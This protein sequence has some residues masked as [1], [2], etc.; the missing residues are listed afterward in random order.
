MKEMN[1]IEVDKIVLRAQLDQIKEVLAMETDTEES[2]LDGLANV[3]RLL[4]ESEYEEVKQREFLGPI[5][6]CI[7]FKEAT[8][9]A[10][11]TYFRDQL[12][13][14]LPVLVVRSAAFAQQLMTDFN[15]RRF[16][17]TISLLSCDNYRQRATTEDSSSPR[18]SGGVSLLEVL[19]VDES[20]PLK[21]LFASIVYY[22]DDDEATVVTTDDEEDVVAMK[23]PLTGGLTMHVSVHAK[24]PAIQIEKLLQRYYEIAEELTGL[25]QST[26]T[27]DVATVENIEGMVRR[28]MELI[29]GIMG[30]W[31][32]LVR[33]GFVA[34]VVDHRQRAIQTQMRSIR[35]IKG[36]L[37]GIEWRQRLNGRLIE[38]VSQGELQMGEPHF[39]QTQIDELLSNRTGA[40]HTEMGSNWSSMGN[41]EWSSTSLAI[42]Y[43][44]EHQRFLIEHRQVIPSL[45]WPVEIVLRKFSYVDMEIPVQDNLSSL[46]TERAGQL[47][48]LTHSYRALLRLKRT[49]KMFESVIAG[50]HVDAASRTLNTRE[51]R[52]KTLL[53]IDGELRQLANE[54]NV[55][56]KSRVYRPKVMRF[57]KRLREKKQKLTANPDAIRLGLRHFLTAPQSVR[58]QTLMHK[59]WHY[60]AEFYAEVRPGSVDQVQMVCQLKGTAAV[61][62]RGRAV[63]KH[64]SMGDM[65]GVEVIFRSAE[66]GNLSARELTPAAI[67]VFGIAVLFAKMKLNDVRVIVIGDDIDLGLDKDTL[68]DIVQLFLDNDMQVIMQN[69]DVEDNDDGHSGARRLL[70]FTPISTTF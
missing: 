68:Q 45:F 3:L 15:D 13:N 11:Q 42:D 19:Q 46:S 21:N 12:Q 26:T 37:N 33:G 43:L 51:H 55:R 32:D 7:H 22:D 1:R 63:N 14:W 44:L 39:Y 24:V 31:T 8:D 6:Q 2:V 18:A 35:R 25:G 38:L 57:V 62:G 16:G 70:N 10:A 64:L 17:G 30:K 48:T 4:A 20:H 66:E 53:E 69:G 65:A 56:G 40:V 60:V 52:Q 41:N 59:L 29:D 47:K 54:C 49:G 67:K 50:I 23:D 58:Q 61:E 28:E 36:E 34:D 5:F 27:N 9:I